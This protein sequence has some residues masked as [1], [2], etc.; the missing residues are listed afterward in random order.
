MKTLLISV[1]PCLLITVGL[2]AYTKTL[3]SPIRPHIQTAAIDKPEPIASATQTNV[4]IAGSP[5]NTVEAK[6]ESMAAPSTAC[7]TANISSTDIQQAQPVSPEP[8]AN[9]SR[10][11][12]A[13]HHVFRKKAS[14]SDSMTWATVPVEP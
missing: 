6:E 3:K 10:P 2:Y 14:A 12:P 8:A 9:S 5:V 13:E 11:K 4:L 7:L 1:V